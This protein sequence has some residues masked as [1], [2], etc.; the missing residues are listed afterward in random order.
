MVSG[1]FT[2]GE[3]DKIDAT[4]YELAAAYKMDKW[5]FQGVYNY[6]EVDSKDTENNVAIEAIYKL[7]KSFRTYAGYKFEQIDDLDDQIQFGLR[8]DF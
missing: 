1:L 8:Y 6:Q 7:N 3:I 5:V 2:T 4:G